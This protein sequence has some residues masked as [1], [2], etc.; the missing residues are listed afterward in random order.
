MGILTLLQAVPS[1]IGVGRNIFEA[2]TG[3]SVDEQITADDLS[4]RIDALPEDQ[5]L[6][7]ST[8]LI[9]ASV[10]TQIEDTRRFVAMASGDADQQR[11]TA[12]P[13]IARSAMR[14]IAMFSN[15]FA[16]L[17][18]FTMAE[19]FLRMVFAVQGLVYPNVSLW[20]L[21]AQAEPITT[22]IWPP[23]IASF[24]VCASIIKKYFGVRERDKAQ[25][26]EIQA[27]KPLQSSAATIAAAGNGIA[28]IINMI[29]G[30]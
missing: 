24:W 6:Q 15:V 3:D 30:K 12:R 28:G 22:M 18:I 13:E 26:F 8:K 14:V 29:R 9:A 17:L 23:L 16:A 27:G 10:R 5:R 1:L 21:F 25:Q 2:V 4:A 20:G 7:I 11:A 19:W